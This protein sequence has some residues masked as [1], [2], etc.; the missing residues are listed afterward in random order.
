M[1]KKVLV[2]AVSLGLFVSTIGVKAAYDFNYSAE[3][4]LNACNMSYEFCMAHFGDNGNL[5]NMLR[6]TTSWR[7]CTERCLKEAMQ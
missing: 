5:D 7:I 3:A 6:C 2:I 4:C 1:K